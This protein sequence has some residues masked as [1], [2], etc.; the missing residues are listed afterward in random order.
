[1]PNLSYN[2]Y[3]IPNRQKKIFDAI[4]FQKHTNSINIRFEL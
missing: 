4:F 3:S 1:M 2:F